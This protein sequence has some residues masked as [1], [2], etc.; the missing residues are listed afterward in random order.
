MKSYWQIFVAVC[1]FADDGDCECC[2]CSPGGCGTPQFVPHSP[3]AQLPLSGPQRRQPGLWA[4]YRR[5][6]RPRQSGCTRPA[7][8]GGS[9]QKKIKKTKTLEN[10]GRELVDGSLPG[11]GELWLVHNAKKKTQLSCSLRSGGQS[12]ASG[13]VNTSRH[14]K[15]IQVQNDTFLNIYTL[16]HTHTLSTR[17]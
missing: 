13:A 4:E 10:G 8:T 7:Q 16:I 15:I 3:P 6:C 5:S 1:Y 2:T 14:S 17:T 11:W 12:G 9:L